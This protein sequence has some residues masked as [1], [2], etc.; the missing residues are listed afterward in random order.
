[1]GER[2]SEKLWFAARRPEEQML[3]TPG[4]VVDPTA[5]YVV[6]QAPMSYHLSLHSCSPDMFLECPWEDV[7]HLSA[8]A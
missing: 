7:A 1:M 3:Q 5:S 4:R 2:R 8:Q 6:I